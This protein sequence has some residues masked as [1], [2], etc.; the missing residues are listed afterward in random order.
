MKKKIAIFGAG[1]SGLAA[2]HTLGDAHMPD[3]RKRVQTSGDIGHRRRISEH[4]QVQHSD[5]FR[6]IGCHTLVGA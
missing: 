5:F 6:E 1:M 4:A 3:A 2:A